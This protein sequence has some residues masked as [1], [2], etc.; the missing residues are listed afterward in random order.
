MRRFL[1]CAALLAAACASPRPTEASG[2]EIYKYEF[3]FVWDQA[4]AELKDAW[5]IAS[6]DRATRT[7]TTEW[8]VRLSPFRT[9]GTRHRLVVAFDGDREAGW[10]VTAKQESE[11]NDEQE[12]T[13][14]QKEADWSASAND[15]ALATRFVFNFDRRMRPNEAWR[16][17]TKR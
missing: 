13:L 17:E 14:D 1:C 8:D 12:K 2:I 9:F 16:R 10:K 6:A 5:R 7:L 15:G 4:Q 3:D 11:E